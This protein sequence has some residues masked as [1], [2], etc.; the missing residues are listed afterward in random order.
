MS[1]AADLQALVNSQW[2]AACHA[3]ATTCRA[4]GRPIDA[5][6]ARRMDAELV[7]IVR[8]LEHV[9]RDDLDVLRLAHNRAIPAGAM[10]AA[11]AA[12]IALARAKGGRHG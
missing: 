12:A 7:G 8:D 3:F 1:S 11:R 2:L 4:A 6:T 10:R 9:G 5:I